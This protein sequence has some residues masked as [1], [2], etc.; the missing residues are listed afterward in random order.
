M[1]RSG[2]LGRY[3]DDGSIEHLGRIDDQVKIRG[4]RIEPAEIELMLSKCAG[5]REAVVRVDSGGTPGEKRLVAYVVPADASCGLADVREQLR[6][7][8]PEAMLPSAWVQM[9]AFP[10]NT[11]GKVDRLRLPTPAAE[12]RADL[13]APSTSTQVLLAGIW[14]EVLRVDR[15]GLHDN[16]FVL[17]GHSLLATRILARLSTHLGRRLPLRI[18]LDHPTVGEMA[19]KV[20]DLM[21]AETTAGDSVAPAIRRQ[22]RS[23]DSNDV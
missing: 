14:Q 17:G 10:L 23:G 16:F 6:E 18:L 20:D 3:L 12:S 1:Y 4:V 11:A 22:R 8:L 7:R 15:V 9:E 21:R 2:D 19:Q 13:A 5:V